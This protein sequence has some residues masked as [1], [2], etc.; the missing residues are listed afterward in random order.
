MKPLFI[1]EYRE[2]SG[3][4]SVTKTIVGIFTG[5][6]KAQDWIRENPDFDGKITK[7][8]LKKRHY[9]VCAFEH[10]NETDVYLVETYN[11]YGDPIENPPARN[12][13][14]SEK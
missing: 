12:T 1:L 9:A 4:R 11:L 10:L 7:E 13:R 2:C 3:T 5:T 14:R 6:K 8:K